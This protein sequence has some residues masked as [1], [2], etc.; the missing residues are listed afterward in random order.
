VS[1]TAEAIGGA[2]RLVEQA[3]QDLEKT[4]KGLGKPLERFLP[5]RQGD[6]DK[7]PSSP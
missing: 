7:E 6:A 5:G 4:L 2:S 3:G 1:E